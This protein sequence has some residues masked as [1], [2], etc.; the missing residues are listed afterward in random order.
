MPFTGKA[1]YDNFTM[2]GEDISDIML[3]LSP[4]EVPFLNLLPGAPRAATSTD[5]GWSE[6]A[7]GPDRIVNS[8]AVNSATAA[9]P[10]QINGFGNQLQ[11][12]MLVELEVASGNMEVAKIGSILGANSIVLDRNIGG[13]GINSLAPGGSMFIISTAELEGSETSGDVT[14]PRTRRK[15]YTQIFKKPVTVSGTDNA[16]ITNPAVGN[17]FDHQVTLR[18]VELLRDLEKAVLRSVATGSIGSASEYRTFNGIRQFITS[19][20]STVA[21]TSFTADPLLYTNDLMQQAWGAGARDL[22]LLLCG[23]QWKRDLSAT[24]ASKLQV[25]QDE[26]SIER[27][28]EV[29]QTDFGLLQVMLT[30]W[31]PDRYMMGLATNRIFVPPLQGRSFQREMLAKTGD[32]EKGHVIGEYTVEIHHP[33]KMFQAHP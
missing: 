12:G 4:T 6:E 21:A 14:R 24:N 15:N 17:E 31:L 22:N 1:T 10:V 30:P 25:R 28:V 5:H 33:D 32:S 19:I 26:K 11:I 9:T 2:I 27:E 29:I 18:S 13:R 20:N 16:V 7:L 8:T 23:A 3:I